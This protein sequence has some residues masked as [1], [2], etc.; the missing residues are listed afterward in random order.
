MSEIFDFSGK[1]RRF[2]SEI[3][4]V[5]FFHGFFFPFP[6]KTEKSPKNRPKFP[7]FFSLLVTMSNAVHDHPF[8]LTNKLPPKIQNNSFI[9]AFFDCQINFERNFS[10]IFLCK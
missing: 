1:N 8:D 6:P 5:D 10:T 3:F 2:F 9:F 7:I 4:S